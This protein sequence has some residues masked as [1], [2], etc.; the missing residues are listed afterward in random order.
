MT[1]QAIQHTIHIAPN[2][3]NQLFIP[4]D[5]KPLH[6]LEF[7]DTHFQTDRE[8]LLPDPVRPEADFEPDAT[9]TAEEQSTGLAVMKSALEFAARFP[10]KRLLVAGHTDSVGSV[11][12]NRKL[13]ERRAENVQYYLTGNRTA[14]AAHCQVN[15]EVADWQT[16]LRWVAMTFGWDTDPGAVDNDYGPLSRD[17]RDRFRVRYN[18]EFSA[19]IPESGKQNAQDWM[20]FFD[21]YDLAVA[22]AMGVGTADLQ[23]VRE[24][25]RPA[26]PAILGC[27]EHW[28]QESIGLDGYESSTNRRVDVLFLDQE[29]GEDLTI[30]DFPG[31]AIYDGSRFDLHAV[32][33]DIGTRDLV[34]IDVHLLDSMSNR[35][36][37]ADW[38]LL[39]DDVVVASGTAN[40][41]GRARALL[42]DDIDSVE[43]VWGDAQR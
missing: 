29:E 3:P 24:R 22:N 12:H 14:W 25:L 19:A 40:D 2:A 18:D 6:R 38:E 7:E 9:P 36:P 30:G 28:P 39:I 15:Y 21:M 5:R 31:E 26:T 27:G 33:V 17:A 34:V 41:E 13:S 42:V 4:V 20:A 8:I 35:M 1:D 43:L 37:E 32:P 10:R 11:S 16:I 23:Q